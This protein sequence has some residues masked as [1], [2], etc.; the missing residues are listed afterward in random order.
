LANTVWWASNLP[1][2]L[3]YRNALSDPAAA[4]SGVLKSILHSSAPSAFGREHGFSRIDTYKDFCQLVPI[5]DYAQFE[6]WID[7]IRQGEQHVLTTEKVNSLAATSGTTSGR[8][9]IPYTRALQQQFNLAIAP[10]IVDLFHTYPTLIRGRAYWSISPAIK[11]VDDEP[12]AVPI[13][14]ED[15]AEY[16]GFVRGMLVNSVMAVPASIRHS[17]DMQSWREHTM[18]HL[19]RADD[20]R[21]ISVWHPSFLTLLLGEDQGQ[22]TAIWPR[23]KLISCW[24]DGHAKLAAQALADQF[25]GVI[26]Q[27][28]GLI[29]TE[30]IVSIPFARKWPLAIRSHFLEFLTDS[31]DVRLAHELEDGKTYEVIL[32]T[33]GGLYRYRL[34]DLVRV[35]GFVRQTPSIRFVS[36][37][38]NVSDRFGEKLAE[39]FVIQVIATLQAERGVQW[40]FAMLA[41]DGPRYS[42]YVQGICPPDI[43]HRLERLL[44]DN[45]HYAYCREL[46]QLEPAA[47]FVV[48]GNA[49]QVV[50][51]RLGGLGQR[52]GDIKPIALSQL[53][54]WAAWFQKSDILARGF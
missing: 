33:A 20:L 5:R 32:T 11:S 14:F 4:Q 38:G 37:A 42:L 1:A 35:E 34:G 50:A 49:D 54:G 51:R 16:L 30:G 19:R 27:P 43:A 46:G 10:W 40:S 23:L 8:K 39:Q 31:G 17:P 3:A 21:L 2:W 44:R 53:D 9:R 13:G 48:A 36:R 12:S 15:D 47:V 25:P 26:V 29:A 52:L 41:P 24:A 6:P 18:H 22:A 28:K 45:P 7:R